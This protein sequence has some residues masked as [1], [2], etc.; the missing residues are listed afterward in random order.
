MKTIQIAALMLFLSG[1]MSGCKKDNS[2]LNTEQANAAQANIESSLQIKWIA[3]GS[4]DG[5]SNMLI[6]GWLR[7][8]IQPKNFVE[9]I[10]NRYFPL[11]PGDTLFYQNTVTDS[12][13]TSIEDIYVTT[14]H[15]IKVI[16]GI[17]CEV[18][19]DY[20]TKNGILAEDT[21]DWYAQDV[22]CNVWYFGED[23]KAY[24][25]DGTYSTEGSFTAGVDGAKPG[26]IMPGNPHYRQPYRQEYYVGHAE[27][28]GVNLTTN[29]TITIGYGTFT[30][31][32]KTREYTV[33]DPGVIENKWYA[34]GIGLIQTNVTI[35]GMEHEELIGITHGR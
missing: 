13:G 1:M 23:T 3:S 7:N 10:N 16:L 25:K 35:G 6:N 22:R 9:G 30:N 8:W 33:L 21:Y 12:S 2:T 32:L 24:N 11:V 28:Q 5:I 34:P 27:D 17:K 14:T 18:I 4:M 31:C 19:H 20:V 29:S 15:D 26:V